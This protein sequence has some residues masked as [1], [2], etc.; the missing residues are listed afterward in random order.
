[1]EGYQFSLTGATMV[2]LPS[3]ALWWAAQNL[4]CVSDLHLGKSERMARRGGAM[5]PP[6]ETTDTIL[7][8]EA[9]LLAT[10]ATTVVCLG[11]SFDDLEAEHG[12][13]ENEKLWL[14]RLQAGRS[15]IL[16]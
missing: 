15:W 4:L 3:G 16:D 9:D 2:A 1:M 12:L 8:L 14:T 5:L 6:Y 10:G 11:D 13:P 7:R